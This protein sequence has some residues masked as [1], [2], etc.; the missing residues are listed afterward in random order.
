[1]SRAWDEGVRSRSSACRADS[2][3]DPLPPTD[4]RTLGYVL[5]PAFSYLGDKAAWPGWYSD[6]MTGKVHDASGKI[7]G[8]ITP[9]LWQSGR[10]TSGGVC[11]R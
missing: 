2:V 10:P 8:G 5:D 3:H 7:L 4:P 11:Q 1:M 6:F 9:A